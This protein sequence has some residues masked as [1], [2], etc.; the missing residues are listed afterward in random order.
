MSSGIKDAGVWK[1]FKRIWVK[2]AGVWKDTQNAYIKD[3]G[4]WKRFFSLAPIPALTNRTFVGS[5]AATASFNNNGTLTLIDS[6]GITDT[7]TG[8]WLTSSPATVSAAI[9]SAYDIMFTYVSG[10]NPSSG[11]TGDGGANKSGA[12]YDIWFNLANTRSISVAA[13]LGTISGIGSGTLVFTAS[14][15]PAGGGV[16]LATGTVT[17]NCSI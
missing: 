15:R 12:G 11:T 10:P 14:I 6:G 2:S 16:I 9:C 13:R 3:A 4:T 1:P 17:L 7:V 8:Q 5:P